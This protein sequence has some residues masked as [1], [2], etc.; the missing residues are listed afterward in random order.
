MFLI[1]LAS[2]LFFFF[3]F[4]SNPAH[5]SGDSE[6]ASSYGNNTSELLKQ[7]IDIIETSSSSLNQQPT[8]LSRNL[9]GSPKAG[10]EDEMADLHPLQTDSDGTAGKNNN[11]NN[12]KG[13]SSSSENSNKNSIKSEISIFFN[14]QFHCCYCSI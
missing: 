10:N 6:L 9:F 13:P 1:S 11:N 4:P 5:G 14:S 3:F 8:S 7:T 12:S 2:I